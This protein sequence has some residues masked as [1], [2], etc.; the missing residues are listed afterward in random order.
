MVGALL[1]ALAVAAA[2]LV[3]ASARLPSLVSTLLL[4]YVVL[5]GGVVLAVLALSPFRAV[6]RGGL[7]AVEGALFAAALGAW[8]LRGRPRL[9]LAAARA[10]VRDV[11]R[12]AP[13]AAFLAVTLAILAYELVLVLT[14]PANNWD[15]LTYHLARAA[16]WAQH[17]GYFW[18]PNAPTARLNELQ[19][20]AEQEILF[21]FVATGKGALYSLPQYAAGLAILLAVFGAARRLGFGARA[22]ACATFS[23]ATFSLPMLEATTAQN[24][25]VA[26]SFPAAAACLLL[27]GGRLE[28]AAAGAAAAIGLGVK[29]TTAPVWPV[30]LPLLVRRGRR[31]FPPAA[32][33]AVLGLV[34]VGMWGY[35][36]N[37]VHTGTLLGRGAEI[38]VYD[39]SPAW[40]GSLHTAL[41]VLYRTFDV[42]VLSYRTMHWLALA[43]GVA[44]LAVG[45]GALRRGRGARAALDAGVVALPF[46]APLLA[47][48]G[49]NVLAWLTARGGIPVHVGGWAGGL[50]RGA[51]EDSSAFGPVG[52][53]F[54]VAAP[55]VAVALY[56]ARR[57]DLRALALGLAL[58]VFLLVFALRSTWDPWTTRFLLVPVALTAPLLAAWFRSRP[59]VVAT[60]AV[61]TVVGV[62]T[63]VHDAR[64]PFSTALGHPWELTW[65]RALSNREGLGV[66][67]VYDQLS[68]SLPPRACVGAVAGVD[69]PTYLLYGPTLARRVF[70]LPVDDAA[71]QAV[72]H[73]LFY[74]VVT[75]GVDRAAADGFTRAGWHER[76]L[77][78]TWLLL[79]S[80]ASGA[81]TGN[82]L[83]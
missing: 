31:A 56:L 22:A 59:A 8:W 10:S 81:R 65:S 28:L 14:M 83:V 24:D 53:V 66:D 12:D 39:A 73:H 26:A 64:K 49:A 37:L 61:A 36:L 47:V 3:A 6:T 25:L 55:F 52:A 75:T 13:C 7:G 76:V 15:S 44:A 5:V 30:L 34:L 67:A 1:I 42:S 4:A 70:Y 63:L 79:R 40:P 38:R 68:R 46:F 23:L 50:N 20:V 82:C 33:G 48:G 19:P 60:A 71:T 78:R 80:P 27:A 29:A 18:I 57:I 58:P 11:L 62:L 43:G 54:V 35:V 51:V 45:A 17:G 41:H 9:P 69:E 16:A 32:A 72:Q 77:G 2:L 21:L 74:V